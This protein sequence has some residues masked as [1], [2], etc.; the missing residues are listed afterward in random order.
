M[1]VTG[2]PTP[3]PPPRGGRSLVTIKYDADWGPETVF[4]FE[5]KINILTL[6]EILIFFGP[7][8]RFLPLCIRE[9]LLAFG[10]Q[11]SL[12]RN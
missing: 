5:E 3:L 1:E 11:I 7:P 2:T 4:L 12:A 10:L 9:T 6:S 8:I